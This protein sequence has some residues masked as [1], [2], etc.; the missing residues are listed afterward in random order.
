MG[1]FCLLTDPE[2]YQAESLPLLDGPDDFRSWIE[3]YDQQ[4]ELAAASA[5]ET[6]GRTNEKNVVAARQEYEKVFSELRQRGE[7]GDL[8]SLLE[9]DRAF[10]Q[11]FREHGVRDPF[12][13]LKHR[14]NQHAMRIY[15]EVV[16]K[17]HAMSDRDR[18]L[19]LVECVFAT[20]AFD[21]GA[22]EDEF[23][24]ALE[25]SAQFLDAVERTKQRPWFVD[26][27]D[28]LAEDLAELPPLWGKAVVFVDNAGADF[29]L[30]IMPLARELALRGTMVSLAAN[31][32]PALNDMTVEDT[33]E[34]VEQ[35]AA[36]DPELQAMI[37]AQMFEVVSSGGDLPLL[38][39]SDVSDELNA[40]CWNDE[41]DRP[42]A[43]LVILEGCGRG[44]ET[45]YDTDFVVDHLRLALL[46]N[47]F[48][49]GKM[50]GEAYDCIC[51][52]VQVDIDEDEDVADGETAESS[53]E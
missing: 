52:Y 31:E 35:L 53:Q 34:V 14:A 28:L 37:S 43:D 20:N 5:I 42:D 7:S 24:K 33:I 15:P 40:T 49:A 18:W 13:K 30:G 10:V 50:G 47:N 2:G 3:H 26:D 6:Y 32:Q 16:R 27:Y 41:E 46:K 48:I 23:R 19:H 38:D 22:Q 39:L 1:H 8:P 25:T 29:V 36:D 44:V 12:N 17:L 11:V 9:M 45:N 4:F 21:V 51:K